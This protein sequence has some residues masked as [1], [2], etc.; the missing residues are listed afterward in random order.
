MESKVRVGIVGL[1]AIGSVHAEALKKTPS[2]ELAALCDINPEVLAKKSAQ[3]G[4]TRTYADYKEM[5]KQAD[6]D[7]IYVCVPNYLHCPITIA[8]LDA[9]KNT[10]CEKPMALNSGEARLMQEKAKASGKV[11]QLGM[12]WR[13]KAEAQTARDLILKGRLGRIYHIRAVM[14]RRRGVPGLGGWFTTKA[15]SGG[16]GLIDIG[17]HFFDLVM[18]L[19]D[20]WQPDRVSAQ[21]YSEFGKRMREYVYTSM[22]AGPP[23]FDGVCDVDDYATG[24]VRFASGA[25]MS[26]E[27]SWAGNN[28]PESF[29]EILGD[30]GGIRAA[31]DGNKLTLFTEED[32]RI[33][34]VV[35]QYADNKAFEVESQRF[36]DVIQGKAEPVATADQ[37]VAV[38]QVID[39]IYASSAM[40][41]EVAIS[42]LPATQPAKK[43]KA[44]SVRAGRRA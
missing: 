34:D 5:V 2:A 15:M 16:G 13:Q 1:G 32:G 38:M 41:R 14:R 35:P 36:M 26:L 40:G 19:S 33:V 27:I 9:G 37:G 11:F 43:S 12:V 42:D 23:K 18:Y 44:A 31:S 20:N 25:T 8:S 29:I 17:V 7:A 3:Y 4:V 39:G 28:P 30:K 6:L 10:F 21:T 24:M 22:W